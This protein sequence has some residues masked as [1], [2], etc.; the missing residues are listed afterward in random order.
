MRLLRLLRR[1]RRKPSP[2][3]SERLLRIY[4]ETHRHVEDLRRAA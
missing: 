3:D 4:R 2:I 1:R